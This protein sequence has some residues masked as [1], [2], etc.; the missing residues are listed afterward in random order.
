MLWEAG[1][2]VE[3][4]ASRDAGR[5]SSRGRQREGQGRSGKPKCPVPGGRGR[6]R[7]V[8]TPKA[9]PGRA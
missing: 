1:Q 7:G 2:I 8:D 6:P 5:G 3:G 9:R 4:R